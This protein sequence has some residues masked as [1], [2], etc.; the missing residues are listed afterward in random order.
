MSTFHVRE[1]DQSDVFEMARVRVDTW[2]SA[3]KGLI[4]DDVLENLSYQ[5]IAENW[6]KT[7]WESRMPGIAVFVAENEQKAIVGIAVC[8]PEQTDDPIYQGEVYVLYVLPQYQNQGIGR[9]L[10]ARCVQHLIQQLKVETMLIWVIAENPY[11]KFYESLGGK[12]VRE[13][14]QEIGG[15]A[16]L[17][18]GY[19]W[20][21]IRTLVTG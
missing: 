3:Y 20:D 16:I 12:K 9:G 17:E 1:A 14:F 2:R 8:G 7:L 15:K 19:G 11:R 5:R 6:K 10:V 4:P 21:E 18:A 13:K